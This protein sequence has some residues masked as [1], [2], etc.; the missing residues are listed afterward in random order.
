MV[1]Q[2]TGPGILMAGWPQCTVKKWAVLTHF[3][4]LNFS[5][6]LENIIRKA[7]SHDIICFGNLITVWNVKQAVGLHCI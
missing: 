1:G 7:F 6:P 3:G 5:T 4:H 2:K